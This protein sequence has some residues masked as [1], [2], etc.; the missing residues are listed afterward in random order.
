MNPGNESTSKGKQPAHP[1]SN[2]KIIVMFLEHALARRWKWG[3]KYIHS[4]ALGKAVHSVDMFP[5]LLGG[6][7]DQCGHGN[8]W[9]V[10]PIGRLDRQHET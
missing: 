2:L 4:N 5:S 3:F 9:L 8:Q 10:A 6:G 7:R 1:E